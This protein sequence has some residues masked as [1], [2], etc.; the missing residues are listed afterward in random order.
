MKKRIISLVVVATMLVLALTGCGIFGSGNGADENT[1]SD[2]VKITDKFSLVAPEGLDY[3]KAYVVKVEPSPDNIV[4]D[5]NAENGMLALYVVVYAKD[6]AAVGEYNVYVLPDQAGVDYMIDEAGE[7][8]Y[9]IPEEDPYVLTYFNDKDAVTAN[10]TMY[11]GYGMLNDPCTAADYAE[12]CADMYGG[13]IV[14]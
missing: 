5:Y 4:G 11:Q 7:G 3:D 6:D 2:G 12:V 10:I 14:E 13:Y 9:T 1:P 8:V